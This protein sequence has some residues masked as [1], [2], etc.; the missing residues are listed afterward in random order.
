MT[1][2]GLAGLVAPAGLDEDGLPTGIQIIGPLWSEMRLL[3]IAREL[4]KVGILPG[5]QAPK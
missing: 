4:E 3:E 2:S 1:P 5:F